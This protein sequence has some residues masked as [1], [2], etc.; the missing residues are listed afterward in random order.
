MKDQNYKH[1]G[2]VRNKKD[3]DYEYYKDIVDQIFNTE[4]EVRESQYK[5][6]LEETLKLTNKT[7]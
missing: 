4:K 2:D 6:L 3:L 5:M 7:E 1:T